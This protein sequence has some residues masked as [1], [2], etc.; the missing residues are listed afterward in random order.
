MSTYITKHAKEQNLRIVD[1]RKPL[2]VDLRKSDIT[3]ATQ[4]NSKDCAFARACKKQKGVRAAYFF[5]ST[6]YLE[7]DDR[8]V[9]YLLPTSVQKEIVS[10]DRSKVMAPGTYQLTPPAKSTRMGAIRKRAT[11]RPGRHQPAHSDIKRKVV[12]RTDLVRTLAEPT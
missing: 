6:A 10:F 8:L 7:F 4:K 12:H 3:E 1:S 5:R 11:K 9:R 2:I